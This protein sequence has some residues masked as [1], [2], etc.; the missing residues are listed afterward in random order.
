M[1]LRI[2]PPT[3]R[4]PSNR[5]S[6]C[7]LAL[8]LVLL[9]S[10]A[11]HAATTWFVDAD[12]PD[13][14]G[15]GL[16]W[17]TAKKSIQAAVDA[18][19]ED[20][21][22]WVADGN[23]A[24]FIADAVAITICS[25]NDAE[26]TVID[27]DNAECCAVLG[28]EL[29]PSGAVLIGFTLKNDYA[30]KGGGAAYGT[31][32]NCWLIDNVA[33][34]GGGAYGCT[35]TNCILEDNVAERDGGGACQCTLKHCALTKNEAKRPVEDE[36]FGRGGGAYE[37]VLEHCTVSENSADIGGGAYQSDLSDC[38]LMKNEAKGYK[39]HGISHLGMGGGAVYSILTDCTVAENKAISG[40]G[41]F[42]CTL[43]NCNLTDNEAYDGGGAFSCI[44]DICFVTNNS[45]S[46]NGGGAYDCTL[47]NCLIAENNAAKG[48]GGTHGSILINCTVAGNTAQLGGGGVSARSTLKNCIVWGN[49]A[50]TDA[51]YSNCVL[52]FSCS[53]PLPAGEGNI[54]ANPVFI[55]AANGDYRLRTSSPCLNKGIN[56]DDIGDTDLVG[57]PRIRHGIVDM[58]AYEASIFTDLAIAPDT[59]VQGDFITRLDVGQDLT[60]SGILTE[61]QLTIAVAEG[62]TV[63]AQKTCAGDE[64]AFALAF[65]LAEGSHDL[66]IIVTDQD[67]NNSTTAQTIVIDNTPPA[68]ANLAITPDTGA[69]GDFITQLAEGEDL[70]LSGD[71]PETLLTVTVAEGETILGQKTCEGDDQAFAFAFPLAEGSHDLTIT[72][73]DIA[74]NSNVIE[75]TVIIDNTLPQLAADLTMTPDTGAP[76]DFVTQLADGEKLTLSGILQEA[77]L[78]VT[79]T[80][81]EN[82]LAQKTCAGDDQA[83]AFAFPLA[84]GNHVLTITITDQ[85]GNSSTSHLTIVIDN[86]SLDYDWQNGWNAL[87]LPFEHMTE[88]T[89]A[90]LNALPCFSRNANSYV[91]TEPT[92]L[93]EMWVFCHNRDQAPA[94]RG[95]WAELIPLD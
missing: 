94:L 40:G 66:T 29:A 79:I 91:K 6:Q 65:P 92:P 59:G 8:F 61:A 30:E 19:A 45:T 43:T 95:K 11:V 77:L 84:K 50:D 58:G 17:E 18:A 24:P 28:T 1:H 12:R 73:T 10:G 51:N 26:Q 69:Q 15:D 86:T 25:V 27:G 52:S 56:A 80:E 76:G 74:G 67:G 9:F 83:F 71:L 14:S 46:E 36:F 13:D 42:N 33:E 82:I 2:N 7:F 72:V 78:T 41:A 37:C 87:F 39:V 88:E 90:A 22:I 70:T 3:T 44:L 62:E 16:S 63:L 34:Y 93:T 89:A 35:L 4:T 54:C 31:L 85:A 48:G 60:L 47:T 5:A 49:E 23:Y 81:G 38:T 21:H 57:N 75:Q 53:E 64:R 55:D 32:L 20:D 68:A